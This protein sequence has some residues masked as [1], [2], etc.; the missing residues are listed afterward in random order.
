MQHFAG[1]CG[2]A[3]RSRPALAATAVGAALLLASGGAHAQ[4]TGFTGPWDPTNPSNGFAFTNFGGCGFCNTYGTGI[5][6]SPDDQTLTIT[7]TADGT[8]DYDSISWGGPSTL[9]AGPVSY[10]FTFSFNQPV[11]GQIGIGAVSSGAPAGIEGTSLEP[12]N[13]RAYGYAADTDYSGSIACTE[14][15][16]TNCLSFGDGIGWNPDDSGDTVMT[17]T[18][19]DFTAVPE[20]ATLTLVGIGLAGL[21]AVRRRRRGG[22][23]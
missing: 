17:L 8:G 6:L 22:Q 7:L 11:V 10:N 13:A 9:P 14:S 3:Q 15:A 2:I 1:W 5:S 20:P 21:G 19:T 18:I 12:T 23:A 16:T 4:I